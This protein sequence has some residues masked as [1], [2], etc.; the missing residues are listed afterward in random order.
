MVGNSV[1]RF[2][3]LVGQDGAGAFF[4]LG[5]FG[6]CVEVLVDD[7]QGGQLC[8]DQGVLVIGG[9]GPGG[10]QGKEQNCGGR[11]E[12]E[13]GHQHFNLADPADCNTGPRT[14]ALTPNASIRG[15]RTSDTKRTYFWGGL[16]GVVEPVLLALLFEFFFVFLVLLVLLVCFV[17]D[18]VVLVLLAGALALSAGGVACAAKVKGSAAAARTIASKLFF[19]I[20]FSCG[21]HLSR[22]F[23]LGLMA[24]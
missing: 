4:M 18:F 7:K 16:A 5:E 22:Q 10:Q 24:E 3:E 19:V 6:V 12:A 8:V 21:L 15:R 9:R 23:H 17:F 2:A 14:G 20:F 13:V 11:C 1:A